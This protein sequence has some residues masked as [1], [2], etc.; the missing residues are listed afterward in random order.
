MDSPGLDQA[1]ADMF[2][3]AIHGKELFEGLNIT[4]WGNYDY[5]QSE[6]DPFY[7]R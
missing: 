1:V 4:V 2:T 3:D 6:W 7:E 5:G